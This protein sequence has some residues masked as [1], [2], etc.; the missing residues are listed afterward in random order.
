MNLTLTA[1]CLFGLEHRLGEEIDRL[2]YHR[3]HTMD[4]RVTFSA[5]EEGIARSNVFLRYAERV[6]IRL[7]AFRAET[8]DSLFEGTRALPWETFIGKDDAFPVKGHSIRSTLFS[9]PDC[10]R[11]VKKAIVERLGAHYGIRRF[12]ESGTRV[13]VV[14]F[15]F[16]DEAALMIDTSGEP[17]YK[18]GYRKEAGGAPLRETLAAAIASISRPREGVL[19]HDPLCGSGTIPIEAA[20]LVN[21]IAP[22]RFRSF[23]AEAFPAVP[24]ALWRLARQEARDCELHTRFEAIASDI[25]P[26]ATALTQE[27]IRRAGVGEWVSACTADARKIRSG[28]RRGTIVTNPP[29]GERLMTPEEAEALYR[30]LGVAFRALAPWQVYVLTSNQNFERLYGRK[31]DKIMRLY[32]GMI[33]CRLYQ[34]FRN[35][36][37]A[38]RQAEPKTV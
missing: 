25:D 4:G 20:M 23:A 38:P 17:L 14:F 36:A 10:Q 24:Q 11:I 30:E 3:L 18:R 21:N 37:P 27:N 35:P 34:F 22:G 12:P 13:Q 9:V 19:L 5:E 7:G 26:A 6:L 29:Y 28:G 33:P 16:K 32:N 1:T 2:G 15:I 31:A 8:F